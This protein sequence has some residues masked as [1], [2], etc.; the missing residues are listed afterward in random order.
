MAYWL[1]LTKSI[2]Q[3]TRLFR[4]NRNVFYIIFHD[5]NIKKTIAIQSQIKGSSQPEHLK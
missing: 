1:G 4:N 2:I 5:L 3:N